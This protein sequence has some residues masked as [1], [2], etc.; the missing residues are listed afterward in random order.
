MQSLFYPAVVGT[1]FV[2]ILFK[3][4]SMDSA[5]Q[6][7]LDTG[8]YYALALIA[9]FSLSFLLNEGTEIVYNWKTFFCDFIEV[10]LIFFAFYYLG[11]FDGKST[12]QWNSFYGCMACIIINEIIW[13]IFAKTSDKVLTVLGIIVFIV[14]FIAC[15]YDKFSE[16]PWVWVIMIMY[17]IAIILFYYLTLWREYLDEKTD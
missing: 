11:F 8:M 13:N 9:F 16:T 12:A 5:S 14:F 17:W 2:L 15:F 10:V 4:A 7:L 1:A 3:I 6:V